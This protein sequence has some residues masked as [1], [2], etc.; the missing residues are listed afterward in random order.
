MNKLRFLTAGESHG[1]GLSII[2]EGLPSNLPLT[3]EDV[4]HHLARRQKGYGRGARMKI[5][6]DR[7]NFVGGVRHGK[8][9]GSPVSMHITN[10]D[11]VNWDKVMNPAA[12][13][14]SDP[15]IK[16]KLEE[17]YLTKVRPGHA[18]FAGAIKYRHDDVRN[19]LER[20]SA[21]ETTSR[22]AA[23][24]VAHRLLAEFGIKVRSHVIRVGSVAVDEK[25]LGS[26]ADSEFTEIEV[27]EL[28]CKDAVTTEKMKTAID[29]ARKKGE[30]LGGI[31][32]L[33]VEGLPIG[34]GSHVHWDRRIDGI[35]A[36]ALMSIHTVKAVGFGMGFD[37]GVYAGSEVHDQ[38]SLAEEPSNVSNYAHH[39]NRAGGIEGGMTNGEPVVCRVALKPIPTLARRP[40][41]SLASID[42]S[43]KANDVA[44]YERS[45]VCVVPAGGVVCEAMLAF[46]LADQLLQKFGGDSLEETKLNFKNYLEYCKTR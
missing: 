26:I 12:V 17:K 44:F 7:I 31:V 14:E 4:N 20:S 19:I 41:D 6:T 2:V 45:D 36:Q 46:V 22:V 24:G 33:V 1:P 11:Y 15:E 18:D 13:D 8:T 43:K 38:I 35:I 32:E 34:L 5:E 16:K 23:G 40:E 28:R 21:R 9:L 29:E 3:V 25:Y 27:S 42:L 39:T 37:A 30:S 10:S